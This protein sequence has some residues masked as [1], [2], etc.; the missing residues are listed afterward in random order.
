MVRILDRAIAI[1]AGFCGLVAALAI[2]VLAGFVLG[3]IISR[4]VGVY[5]PGLTNYAGYCLAIASAFGMAYTFAHQGHIRVSLLLDRFR[6]R[7]RYAWE[8]VLLLT[9]AT[10]ASYL[11]YYLVTMTMLSYDFQDRSDGSDELLIYLPQLPFTVGFF[12]FALITV[13][14]SLR[15]LLQ[16]DLG[17]QPTGTSGGWD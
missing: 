5:V 11:A 1:V 17:V 8:L 6:G 15:A 13:L 2:V 4:M 14:A 10:L 3:S 9:S 7:V 16:R 12:F